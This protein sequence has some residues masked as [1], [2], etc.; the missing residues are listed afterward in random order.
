MKIRFYIED[1]EN[2]IKEKNI[3]KFK[4]TFSRI[5]HIDLDIK[6]IVNFNIDVDIIE[7]LT[8]MS[9]INDSKEIRDYLLLLFSRS[10]GIFSFLYT[11]DNNLKLETYVLKKFLEKFN[12]IQY[13]LI[14]DSDSSEIKDE[15]IKHGR[16]MMKL[17]ENNGDED[18]IKSFLYQIGFGNILIL[19]E[20]R[21]LIKYTKFMEDL[22]ECFYSCVCRRI[23]GC[24]LD[25]DEMK[26]L[27]DE[28]FDINDK[29]K[30][31]FSLI[32]ICILLNKYNI[33]NLLINND[34]ELK[35]HVKLQLTS[36]QFEISSKI[37]MKIL[38]LISSLE[39]FEDFINFN[40]EFLM[41][42]SEDEVKEYISTIL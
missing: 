3:V 40:K 31:D 37:D 42:Y 8:Y 6:H 9:I 10:F 5:S 20:L 17:I 1:L 27:I 23:F 34:I 14:I 39:N 13:I 26:L 7:Y 18:L 32:N 38:S 21:E 24:L 41:K 4:T 15:Y 12:S 2:S 22:K 36:E 19:F 30:E 16:D 35:C 11:L 33:L 29:C 28:G 25:E